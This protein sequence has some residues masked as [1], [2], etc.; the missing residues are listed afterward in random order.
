[1]K[2]L[3]LA[4]LAILLTTIVYAQPLTMI[5]GG[6]QFSNFSSEDSESKFGIRGG[7]GGFVPLGQSSFYFMPQL[8]YAQK[9]QD[10]GKFLGDCKI[11]YAEVPLSLGALIKF[12]KNVGMGLMVGPYVGVGV[13]G[14]CNNPEVA[15]L[16]DAIKRVDAGLSAGF[17]F[18]IWKIFVFADYDYGLRDLINSKDNE[19]GENL[20]TRSFSAGIGFA[21]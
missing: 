7:I 15:K 8:V 13:A 5:K 6:A 17:Q 12:S 10:A 20:T 9:G 2:K 18:H 11:H 1:M 4:V 16:F 14:E 21:Y 19:I 3:I